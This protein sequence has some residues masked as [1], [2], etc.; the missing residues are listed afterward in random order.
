MLLI[1]LLNIILTVNL[2]NLWTN[3]PQGE[4]IIHYTASDERDEA[5]FITEEAVKTK[6]HYSMCLME[7]WQYYIVQML[8]LV[9]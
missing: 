1:W 6:N 8:N 2:K 5:R 3:N 7:I 4:K 9:H